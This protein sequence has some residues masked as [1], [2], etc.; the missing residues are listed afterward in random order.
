MM[1]TLRDGLYDGDAMDVLF[2]FFSCLFSNHALPSFF[3]FSFFFFL[4]IIFLLTNS[5]PHFCIDLY[6]RFGEKDTL[7]FLPT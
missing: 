2:I 4:H 6:A 1:M 7:E 3:S 5:K